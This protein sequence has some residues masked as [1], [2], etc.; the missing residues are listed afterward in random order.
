MLLE[1]QWLL[2]F[3]PEGKGFLVP[4]AGETAE[5][6]WVNTLFKRSLHDDMGSTI[7]FD[8]ELRTKCAVED[9]A[10]EMSLQ[11]FRHSW[12]HIEFRSEVYDFPKFRV[13][14]FTDYS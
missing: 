8:R 10:S 2:C 7:I 3:S 12:N 6:C 13:I 1:G 11:V 9:M 14:L 5:S 4:D